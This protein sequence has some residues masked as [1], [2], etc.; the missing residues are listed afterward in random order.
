LL[1]KAP[2]VI[3]ALNLNFRIVKD[4][5]SDPRSALPHGVSRALPSAARAAGKGSSELE[6]KKASYPLLGAGLFGEWKL[7]IKG[8]VQFED[9]DPRLSQEPPLTI[10]SML[11]Y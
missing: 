10:L 7:L 8:K 9:I 5:Q 1:P 3:L 6:A 2:W 11:G 4:L